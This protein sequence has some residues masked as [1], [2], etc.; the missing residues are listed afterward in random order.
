[1][2]ATAIRRRRA[3]T[4][5]RP[6]PPSTL[7][8]VAALLRERPD[9]HPETPGGAALRRAAARRAAE[10]LVPGVPLRHVG[11]GPVNAHW[12]AGL[13]LGDART[14][15]FAVPGSRQPAVYVVQSAGPPEW[16][17]ASTG[18]FHVTPRSDLP[19]WYDP[20]HDHVF[21]VRPRFT[22]KTFRERGR[23]FEGESRWRAWTRFFEER[24]DL[25]PAV[26]LRSDGELADGTDLRSELALALG[27]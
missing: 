9:L 6:V 20:E 25:V 19:A 24:L 2:T 17:P 14:D 22:L 21:V 12:N 27:G 4:S 18:V 15:R 5:A 11:R 16:W 26:P 1:M 7:E 8:D 10:R 13:P 23:D 3:P